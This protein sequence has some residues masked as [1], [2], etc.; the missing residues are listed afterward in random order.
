[1][2]SQAPILDI[3]YDH[4]YYQFQPSNFIHGSLSHVPFPID[5]Q[6]Q[7]ELHAGIPP[8]FGGEEPRSM[9]L[10][11]QPQVTLVTNVASTLSI[12]TLPINR[13]H[14]RRECGARLSA[15]YRS[16]ATH[17]RTAHN[18]Q[19]VK[20]THPL[21][22]CP[23]ETCRC[24]FRKRACPGSATVQ[25]IDGT[26]RHRTHVADLVRHCMDKHMRGA[27]RVS[28]D[29]CGQSFTRRES[30]QRHLSGGC[31]NVSPKCSQALFMY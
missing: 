11:A 3:A 8:Y 2:N 16:V 24:R 29:R 13:D 20:A 19:D 12:C 9:D 10:R 15:D 4:T 30:R 7:T 31:P 14:G 18:I 23:D 17:L 21:I 1:M 22:T 5:N 26:T 6:F 27:E 28:C 25:Q